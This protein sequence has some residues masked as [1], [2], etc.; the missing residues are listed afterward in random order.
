MS[1]H[2]NDWVGSGP[3]QQSVNYKEYNRL[4]TEQ[5]TNRLNDDGM[6]NE[7]LKEVATLEDI[8]GT[9]NEHVLLLVHSEQK[10]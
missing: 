1:L 3:K 2:R 8:E 6:V 5:F 7:I 4:L 9:T 10:K